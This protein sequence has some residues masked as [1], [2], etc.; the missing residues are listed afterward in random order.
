M[1]VRA[2]LF[3][4]VATPTLLFGQADY[5]V[6]I[7]H[8]R[9]FLD[10]DRLRRLERDAERETPRWIRLKEL[11]EVDAPLEDKPATQALL[12]RVSKNQAAG[13]AARPSG[14]SG[15][16]RLLL[17]PGQLREAALV[18]DWTQDLLDDAQKKASS[19]AW[20]PAR[21]TRPN[22]QVAMSAASVTVFSPP[23]PPATGTAPSPHWARC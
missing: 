19:T 8:P 2:L 9:L 13:K 18:F 12:W 11:L 7:D 21:R 5:R 6:Y 10:A 22:S 14:P 15:R 16:R 4:I 17:R 3:V 1:V 20:P 23:S